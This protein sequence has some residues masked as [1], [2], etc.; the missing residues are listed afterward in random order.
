VPCAPPRQRPPTNAPPTLPHLSR[1]ARS[2]Q[3]K[4]RTTLKF[5]IGITPCGSISFVSWGYPGSITDEEIVEASGM[6]ELLQRGDA[7][8]ADRGFNGFARARALGIELI[9]PAFNHA[10]GTGYGKARAAFTPA[11]NERTYQ[12][13]HLRIH[14]ERMMRAIKA[15]WGVFDGPIDEKS[16]PL[17][18]RHLVNI[19]ARMTTWGA[20]LIGS[21][22]VTAD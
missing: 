16:I 7:V 18:S 3:Y 11:E 2:S 6:Y 9:I 4:H 5:L 14:V 8:M 12:I 19:S 22:Y 21:E 15:G 10:K 13:A 20:P 17:A 1:P